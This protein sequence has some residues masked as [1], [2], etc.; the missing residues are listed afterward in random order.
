[1]IILLFLMLL[2]Q[3]QQMEPVQYSM[4]LPGI[5]MDETIDADAQWFGLF[6]VECDHFMLR[7][8]ELELVLE[9][10]SGYENERPLGRITEFPEETDP[11][12]ILVSSSIPVFTSGPVSILIDSRLPLLPDTTFSLGSA[13]IHTMGVEVSEEGVFLFAPGITQHLTYTHP[14]EGPEGPFVDLIWAGDLDRD[15]KIDLLLNDVGNSY[16]IYNWV[17]FL[18]T[19]A[20]RGQLVGRVAS[21]Y[22]V[23]Y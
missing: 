21:F 14:G 1:M 8:V 22:D 11:P 23:Y 9:E 2:A 17:L 15:G 16:L 19:E 5:V 12:M 13:D 7:P 3:G 6:R 20:S 4:I 18:S 10:G